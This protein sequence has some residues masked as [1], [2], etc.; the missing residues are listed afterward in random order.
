MV[1]RIKGFGGTLCLHFQ[2]R[3][4][5][6]LNVDVVVFFPE[7]FSHTVSTKM[8]GVTV[9]LVFTFMEIFKATKFLHCC[10][11]SPTLISDFLYLD[12]L[13]THQS[14]CVMKLLTLW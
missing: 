10:V 4:I 11:S 3:L 9:A 13:D 14:A 7:I 5:F 8:Y 1:D 12:F 2:G 6:C